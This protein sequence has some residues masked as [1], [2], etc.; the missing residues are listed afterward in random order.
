MNGCIQQVRK[1]RP[2]DV[3]DLAC[4]C[5]PAEAGEFRCTFCCLPPEL[6]GASN[7]TYR[8]RLSPQNRLVLAETAGQTA[9]VGRWMGF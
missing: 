3:S 2:R 1:H 4:T 8:D 9:R 7:T 5:K 6:G